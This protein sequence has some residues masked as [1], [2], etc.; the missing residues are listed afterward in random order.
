VSNL[1][2]VRSLANW[3]RRIIGCARE[4]NP[5]A[6]EDALGIVSAFSGGGNT[7]ACLNDLGIE[8]DRRGLSDAAWR[9]ISQ[10]AK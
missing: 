4:H 5:Q 6:V 7:V 2:V 8:A 3:R 1:T 10:A 9:V